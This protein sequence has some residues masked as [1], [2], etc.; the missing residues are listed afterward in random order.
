MEKE[1]LVEQRL[2]HNLNHAG[3]NLDLYKK[4]HINIY[5]RCGELAIYSEIKTLAQNRETLRAALNLSKE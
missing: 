5:I 3:K 4:I 1:L 2:V